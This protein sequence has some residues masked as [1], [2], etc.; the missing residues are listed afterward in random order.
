[1][2]WSIVVTACVWNRGAGVAIKLMQLST[3]ACN[4]KFSVN[5]WILVLSFNTVSLLCHNYKA[6]T[7]LQTIFNECWNTVLRAR[8]SRKGMPGGNWHSPSCIVLLLREVAGMKL[9]WHLLLASSEF[10]VSLSMPYMTLFWLLCPWCIY[11]QGVR[12]IPVWRL[13]S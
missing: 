8:R 1:M 9:K 11:R 7:V 2:E 6:V 5:S 4:V 12:G 3:E 13:L 10:W